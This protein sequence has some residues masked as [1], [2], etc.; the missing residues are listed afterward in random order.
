MKGPPGKFGAFD[1]RRAGRIICGLAPVTAAIGGCGCLRSRF[2]A[3]L[4]KRVRLTLNWD[5]QG[6]TGDNDDGGS[7]LQIL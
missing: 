5:E 7:G 3:A 6:V 1:A 4:V 2:G